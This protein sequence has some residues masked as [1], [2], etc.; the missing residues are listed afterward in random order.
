MVTCLEHYFHELCA[1]QKTI[2][3]DNYFQME[4]GVV[5]SCIL[6]EM[7]AAR[8][9]KGAFCNNKPIHVSSVTGNVLFLSTRKMYQT[10]KFV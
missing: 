1:L 8:R 7:F 6:D 10:N 2:Y 5:F 4:I 9:G 3:Y